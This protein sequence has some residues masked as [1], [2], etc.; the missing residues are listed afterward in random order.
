[1]ADLKDLV[2]KQ[3]KKFG[4]NKKREITRLIYEISKRDKAPYKKIL[5]DL[6]DTAYPAIKKELLRKRFPDSFNRFEPLTP[7]LPKLEIRPANAL[8]IKNERLYP[9][10]IYLEEAV[11][12]SYLSKRARELFPMAKFHR[13][14]SLKDF[15]KND[16][17]GTDPIREYNKRRDNFFIIKEKYDFFKKCPC[18]RGGFSCGYHIFNL[19]FGCI[20]ECTYC[21]LQEYTNCPGIVLPSNIE[22]FF[23]AFGGYERPGMRIGTGEFTDSLA[24]DNITQYSV[25]LIEFFKKKAGI[26][27]EFKTKSDNIANILKAKH[28]GNIVI[29]WSLNPPKIIRQNEFYSASLEKRLNSA[30]ECARAGY[31]VGFHLDPLIHYKEWGK[32]YSGLINSLFDKLPQ[33]KIAWLSMGTLRFNPC[34][35]TII[36][37]RFPANKI[38]DEE[39]MLDFDN[40]LRYPAKIR[41]TMYKNML[42]WIRKRARK[43]PVYLC[44]EGKDIMSICS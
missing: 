28:S 27:F 24:L 37:N 42:Y 11:Y 20:F 8:T 2:K 17:A 33:D 26:S 5:S 3:F 41:Y 38:L 36:E 14:R 1:M 10:N 19:G 22:D 18:T 31:R 21:Y 4:V 25:G 12:G 7:Y 6:T 32:G 30:L 23:A 34:L 13:I 44:M 9:K 39:L 15:V 29:S 40:K 35:K 16:I 43:V